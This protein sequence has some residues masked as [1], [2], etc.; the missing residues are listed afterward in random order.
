MPKQVE[1]KD[2]KIQFSLNLSTTQQSKINNI[3]TF[4]TPYS[5]NIY[6]VGGFLRDQILGI[7]SDDIDIEVYDISQSL[8]DDLMKQL[9][10]SPLSKDFFV[11]NFDG[12]DI[13]LPRKEI[14]SGT[15]YH[16]FKMELESNPKV[17]IL[18]RDFTCN[19]LIYHLV[20]KELYD[21]CGGF[22]D[23]KTKTLRVVSEDR[24]P[25]DN[26]RFLRAIRFIA[27]FGFT[28][29][30]RLKTIL[31]GMNL[32]DITKTKIAKELKKIFD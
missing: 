9:G 31:Q 5:N 26:L 11:Y 20:D 7:S 22:D 21:F 18:R 6:L 23:I 1:N 28:P 8:F 10:A 14:K 2:Y 19:A 24:F 25:E 27:K 4:L 30:C 17:A 29:D 12:I 15:G 32:D 3:I 13:S 16:G